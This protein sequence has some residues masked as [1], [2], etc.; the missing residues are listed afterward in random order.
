MM[1]AAIL[2]IGT[3]LITGHTLNTHGQYITQKLKAFGYVVDYHL[4][5]D[6][7]QTQVVKSLQF[8]AEQCDLI[9]TTGGLG[10]TVDD[11][12]RD[13]IADFLG[14][15]LVEN[16]T[17][18]RKLEDYFTSKNYKLTKN[19]YKQTLF[20]QNATIIVNERGTADSFICSKDKLKIMALPGP[21][22]EMQHVL[23]RSLS[24]LV[25]DGVK[26]ARS[27]KLFGCGESSIDDMIKDIDSSGT[28]LGIYAG[29]GVI[30]I[31]VSA[32]DASEEAAKARVLPV[33]SAIEARVEQYV[34]ARDELTL[35]EIVVNLLLEHE[36]TIG[37]AESCTGGQLAAEL[38]A[39]AGVSK[40]F[41]GGVVSYS[42]AQKMRLLGVSEKTLQAHGA[43]SAETALEMVQGLIKLTAS[44]IG[45]AITGI[46]GPGGGTAEKPVGLV[47]IGIAYKGQFFV[48]RYNFKRDR[49]KNRQYATLTALKLV[50]D[51][52]VEEYS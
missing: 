44:D 31:R 32:H 13:C 19:N 42:N 6:D 48:E 27:L 36:L 14:L 11:I 35:A 5:C 49:A 25:Q 7:D 24:Y 38:T 22:R 47:Y 21:P 15:P 9:I 28:Q 33:Y 4:C 50:R 3:E 20:P 30:T 52:I 37:V 41:I 39:I 16:E 18:K 8:L 29:G 45:V 40:A 26:Y 46:A 2:S 10:P 34:Y 17:A 51:K 43:V 23:E 12:T 1:H